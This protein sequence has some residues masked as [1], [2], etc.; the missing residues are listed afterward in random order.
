MRRITVLDK[1]RKEMR[2]FRGNCE[3]V[4]IFESMIRATGRVIKVE[5]GDAEPIFSTERENPSTV[6]YRTL[7]VRV[8]INKK[9][10]SLLKPLAGNLYKCTIRYDLTNN[11]G[12]IRMTRE[13]ID[14][15][16]QFVPDVD[17]ILAATESFD[18]NGNGVKKKNVETQLPD[19]AHTADNRSA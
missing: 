5:G 3:Q 14:Y 2:I 1:R 19:N 9:V 12:Y 4:V 10:P 18:E 11:K 8:D 7:L 15:L 6:F 13:V 16:R 17:R